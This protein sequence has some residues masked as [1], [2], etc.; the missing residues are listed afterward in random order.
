MATIDND[1]DQSSVS[2][3]DRWLTLVAMLVYVAGVSIYTTLSMTLAIG[4]HGSAHTPGDTADQVLIGFTFFSIV[5]YAIGF[6]MLAGVLDV[7]T[8]RRAQPLNALNLALFAVATFEVIKL[9]LYMLA[10]QVWF[11]ITATV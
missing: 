7:W 8:G 2:Q 4:E 11:R 9:P 1:A 6:A 5:A 3:G 10:F